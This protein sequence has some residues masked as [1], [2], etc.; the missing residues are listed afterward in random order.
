MFKTMGIVL[1]SIGIMMILIGLPFLLGYSTNEFL[2]YPLYLGLL[3][4]VLFTPK[5]KIPRR[6]KS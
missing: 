4:T 1:F 2:K 3:V 5:I 6:K